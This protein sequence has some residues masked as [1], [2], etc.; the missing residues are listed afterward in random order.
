MSYRITG[1]VDD[2]SVPD[3]ERTPPKWAELVQAVFDLEPGKSL[4]VKFDDRHSAERAR[5]AVRDKT[6]LKAQ[7]VICR[8]RLVE[9]DDGSATLYLV[10]L[11]PVE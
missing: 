3:W 7:A 4:T 1:V 5:N 9:H 8:T 10:R 2:N 11:H 6:N